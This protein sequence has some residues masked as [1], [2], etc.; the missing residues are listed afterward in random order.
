MILALVH[1]GLGEEDQ[2]FSL[3]EK[4]YDDRAFEVLSF[5][6]QLADILLDDPRFQDI[7]RRMGLAGEPGY[8]PRKAAR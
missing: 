1:L 8:A 7:L 6:G 4:A 3:L 2:A 5:A